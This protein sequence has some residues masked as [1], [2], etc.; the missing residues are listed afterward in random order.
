M[1]SSIFLIKVA[2]LRFGIVIKGVKFDID[3]EKID[4]N[5]TQQGQQQI[6]SVPFSQ[7]EALFTSTSSTPPDP[8]RPYYAPPEQSPIIPYSGH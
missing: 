1:T 4:V 7:I 2:L 8:G 6:K 5:Y 3:N